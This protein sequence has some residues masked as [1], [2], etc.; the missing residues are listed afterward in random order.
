MK[1]IFLLM[2]I[3]IFLFSCWKTQKIEEKNIN[4]WAIISENK[5][6]SKNTVEENDVFDLK[7]FWKMED[8]EKQLEWYNFLLSIKYWKEYFADFSDV[9]ELKNIVKEHEKNVLEKKDEIIKEFPDF[10]DNFS[11]QKNDD[12]KISLLTNLTSYKTYTRER[13]NFPEIPNEEIRFHNIPPLDS[14]TLGFSQN[15]NPKSKKSIFD[16]PVF[17][18]YCY[19]CIEPT[20]PKI[21]VAKNVWNNRISVER[22]WQGVIWNLESQN[23]TFE[24][25]P[26]TIKIDFSEL[27]PVFDELKKIKLKSTESFERRDWFLNFIDI[28]KKT[29][30]EEIIADNKKLDL[31]D[32]NLVDCGEKDS[33]YKCDVNLF[34]IW[35][36]T[37]PENL[38]IKLK[39][40]KN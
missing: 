11:I 17:A 29:E 38:T 26:N 23:W 34:A 37:L 8:I 35:W 24:K 33:V 19:H 14:Y 6:I 25:L 12:R 10:K 2:I 40:I 30:I 5:D 16:F 1:K 28:E 13:D 36:E 39:E 4:S 27:K 15:Y 31:N 22:T 9:P 20:A 18:G 3:S 21:F 32:K 7:F